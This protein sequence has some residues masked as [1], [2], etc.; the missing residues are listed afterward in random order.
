MK[1]LLIALGFIT[2][3]ETVALSSTPPA[4]PL[5]WIAPSEVAADPANRLN[6]QLSNGGT[7]VVQLRPDVAPQHVY[8][9]QQLA[10]AGFYNGLAFHR[11]IPGFMAQ[12]G[13]PQGTGQGGSQ[14]PDLKAE[15]SKLPHLRGVMAMARAQSPDSANSQFYIMLS[16][17]LTLDNKY[18]VLGRVLS[19]MDVV[20]RIAV[21]EPP[22][23]PTKIVRAWIDGPLPAAPPATPETAPAEAATAH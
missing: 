13:D 9:I 10:S 7:V 18:T 3:F 6:L 20:D 19:G 22:A 23:D 15:F 8:R 5:T 1:S 21:G 11:V 16:A 2:F 12:G 14:M 4:A 17:G